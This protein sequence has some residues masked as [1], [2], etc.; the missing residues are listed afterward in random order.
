M[1]SQTPGFLED[2]SLRLYLRSITRVPLLTADREVELA[3]RIERG[4]LVAK[5]EMVE[6]N[7]RLV[8]SIA[9]VTGDDG[10]NHLVGLDG[11]DTI[12]GNSGQDRIDAGA[13]HDVIQARDGAV[14]FIECGRGND[15]ATVDTIDTV[16]GC[17]TVSASSELV[18]DADGDNSAKPDDCD[19]SRV[20][21]HPG[22]TDLPDNGIDEDCSG[23][24]AQIL[25]RD[26]DGY[27]R[28]LDCDDANRPIHPGATDIPGNRLDED[29]RGGPA[30]YPLLD[31][32]VGF[33]VRIYPQYSRFTELFVR[34]G[35][36][37]SVVRV[38]CAGRGCPFRARTRTVSRD[39]ARLPLS[40]LL[41]SARL[42]PGTRLEVRITKPT[43]VGVVMRI[44]TRAG[45]PLT[46]SELCLPPRAVRARRCPFSPPPAKSA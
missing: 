37:G 27:P 6:A 10:A 7:L 30:R 15:E 28:P 26:G 29:C 43:A 5:Q 3:R 8:V 13:E 1:P 22:A 17:E 33:T 35:R 40:R 25:D 4:D 12:D 9:K 16:S 14:D 18:R 21:I 34:R 46:R 44:T 11:E 38:S 36:A 39:V 2:D 41:R 23:A 24:D 32:S 45:K 19:D 20:A 31:S 42:R